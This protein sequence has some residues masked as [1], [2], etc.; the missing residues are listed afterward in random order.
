MRAD[1]GR[2]GERNARLIEG[3]DFPEIASFRRFEKPN[4]FPFLDPIGDGRAC[5][6]RRS[7][8]GRLWPSRVLF[9]L[10]KLPPSGV[11]RREAKVARMS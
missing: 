3:T 8:T 4:I 11:Q 10:E 6:D 5:L 2:N 7:Q 9:P 1:F